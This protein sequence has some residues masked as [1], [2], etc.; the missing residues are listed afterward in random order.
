VRGDNVPLGLPGDL[1][2]DSPD[3]VYFAGLA[4]MHYAASARKARW[5]RRPP[6]RRATSDARMLTA[7]LSHYEA[8]SPNDETAGY[9][10]DELKG[11]SVRLILGAPG[12]G[13]TTLPALGP[14][15]AA[16]SPL[17]AHRVV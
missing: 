17:R 6:S 7:F 9:L 11:A 3:L 2:S 8:I 4:A 10:L 16:P 14:S 13:K 1:A 5:Q 15:A 12:A